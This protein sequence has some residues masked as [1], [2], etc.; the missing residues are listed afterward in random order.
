MEIWK[1][2]VLEK[3][4]VKLKVKLSCYRPLGL[5]EVEAPRI[6]RQLVHEGGKVVRLTHWPPLP[7]SVLPG[8][9]FC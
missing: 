5:E 9:H 6:C 3:L 1:V 8:T 2:I 4:K 7:P